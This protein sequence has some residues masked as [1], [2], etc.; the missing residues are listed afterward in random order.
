MYDQRSS[1]FDHQSDQKEPDLV[2]PPSDLPV[3][4]RDA[5]IEY[6]TVTASSEGSGYSL[7]E[8]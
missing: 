7:T 5:D 8:T 4:N 6:L 1:I 2:F 3:R